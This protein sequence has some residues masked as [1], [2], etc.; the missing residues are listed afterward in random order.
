MIVV[1][2][3]YDASNKEENPV[4]TLLDE[5]QREVPHQLV[6]V[7]VADDPALRR[8]YEDHLP[9]LEIGPY[10]LRDPYITCQDILVALMS[11]RDRKMDLERVGDKEYLRR[12]E[13]SYQFSGTDKFSFWM[14]NCYMLLFNLI[15]FVYVGLPFL[16]PVLMKVGAPTP[17]KV[18]YSIY[19]P[20]CHQLAFR[21]W[22]LF[23]EQSVYPRELAHVE[24]LKTY[25]EI[26]GTDD[27][28][29]LDARQFIGNDVLGY[30]VAFCE[31]DIAIYG[32]ILL[33][34]VVFAITGRKIKPLPWYFWIILGIIPI[35]LDGGSQLPSLMKDFLP[36]WLPI[37]E[38]ESTPFLRTLTGGMFG[39]STAWY[40]Y[41]LIE[42]TM[43]ETRRVLTRKKA[44]VE[45][46][47]SNSVK[48]S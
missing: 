2:L 41:P 25:E 44:V 4:E 29:I 15:V 27:V 36:A 38:R 32:G 48:L 21:S 42:E 9:V 17:A 1:T 34:G 37:I 5:L 45:Q 8:V 35:G 43:Q 19:S 39:V 20:L 18:I 33:F 22:F 30:K 46:L 14:S 3:Y 11:A 12:V 13:K 23:G 10:I 47:K 24:G 40:L 7:N 31:R 16:A 28:E 6:K 26:A